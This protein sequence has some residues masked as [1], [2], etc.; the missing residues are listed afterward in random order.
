MKLAQVNEAL[1]HKI[2]S[3]S[4]YQWNCYGP[5]A[6]Y[7]DYESDYACVSVIYDTTNQVVYQA[8]VSVKRDAWSEDSRPYRWLH[9]YTKEAYINES[10]DR[11]VDPDQAWDDV[12]WLDL[13]TEEDF[14]EKAVAMFNGDE[15]DT[16][17]QVPLD[18]D[19]NLLMHLAMEAHK[20]DITLN[21]MVEIVLQEAIDRHKESV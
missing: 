14:L 10:K 21:K 7:L 9:P 4:E 17:V 15:W 3:G 8:E 20:R 19:D 5:T 2:T 12:K 6:R 16:R 18:L 11:K 13:E 1:D